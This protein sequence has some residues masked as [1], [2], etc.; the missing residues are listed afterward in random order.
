MAVEVVSMYITWSDAMDP[1]ITLYHVNRTECLE[2][3]KLS[4]SDFFKQ[5]INPDV[6]VTDEMEN[7]YINK[8][9]D[10]KMPEELLKLGEEIFDEVY[11]IYI[12]KIRQVCESLQEGQFYDYCVDYLYTSCFM[13]FLT[14]KHIVG[15]VCD[16]MMKMKICIRKRCST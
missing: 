3:R 13:S 8:L 9:M 16:A 11:P 4:M 1:R 6:N 5:D 10:L 14:D 12:P 2:G 7:I 15:S